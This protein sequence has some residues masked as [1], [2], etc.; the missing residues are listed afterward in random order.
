MKLQVGQK[1]DVVVVKILD[2]GAVVEMEDKST[3]LIHISNIADEYIADVCEY[4]SVG[5]HYSAVCQSGKHK[6]FELSLKH[7]GL[8]SQKAKPYKQSSRLTKDNLD[9][10]I[11][12]ANRTYAEKE[13]TRAKHNRK[14]R[15]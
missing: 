12:S 6:E 7:L 8:K 3:E 10:M 5:E 11:E 13:Q 2:F 1:Y 15:K 14:V 9:D 4:V